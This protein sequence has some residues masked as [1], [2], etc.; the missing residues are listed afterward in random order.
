M[1]RVTRYLLWLFFVVVVFL[2]ATTEVRAQ[3]SNNTQAPSAPVAS[4]ATPAFDVNAAV[5]TYLAKMPPAERA[6]SKQIRQTRER[7]P[8]R[9][10]IPPLSVLG[11]RPRG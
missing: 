2:V 1:V 5:E 11:L 7:H 6:R 4:Q 9:D 10:E 8:C 3:G